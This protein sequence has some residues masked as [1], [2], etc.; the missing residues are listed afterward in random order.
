[1]KISAKIAIAIPINAM[2]KSGQAIN[3]EGAGWRNHQGSFD[4]IDSVSQIGVAPGA[5]RVSRR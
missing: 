5:H 2:A 1:M 3:I 4:I